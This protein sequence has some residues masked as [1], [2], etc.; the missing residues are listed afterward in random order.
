MVYH[1]EE[2]NTVKISSVFVREVPQGPIFEQ[3]YF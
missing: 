1:M 2:N 3:F